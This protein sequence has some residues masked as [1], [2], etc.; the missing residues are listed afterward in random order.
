MSD[1]GMS[2]RAIPTVVGWPSMR[3]IAMFAGFMAD[4]GYM[5][6]VNCTS[7]TGERHWI[8][9]PFAG[10]V[11]ALHVSAPPHCASV[12]QRS[13]RQKFPV[14]QSVSV[15]QRVAVLLEQRC[16]EQICKTPGGSSSFSVPVW[17]V[18]PSGGIG[19]T[20]AGF[21][22]ATLCTWLTST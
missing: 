3:V 5:P 20:A 2:M 11:M 10:S 7:M 16:C 17:N 22:G 4:G 14:P 9:S 21:P 13:G 15:V 19:R 12:W 18:Q 1:R 8:V 6:S